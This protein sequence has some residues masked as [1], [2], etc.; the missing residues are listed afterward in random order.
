[1]EIHFEYDGE[2][3]FFQPIADIHALPSP[4][5]EI[6]IILKANGINGL[7]DGYYDPRAQF[8]IVLLDKPITS[9][10][11]ELEKIGRIKLNPLPDRSVS[12]FMHDLYAHVYYDEKLLAEVT[13]HRAQ[14]EPPISLKK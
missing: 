7:Y 8:G 6:L 14:I 10:F 11:R 3:Y 13:A 5:K 2:Y 4:L 1:M 9:G 12:I